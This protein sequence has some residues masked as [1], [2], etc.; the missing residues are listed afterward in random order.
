MGSLASALLPFPADLPPDGV[1][2][3]QPDQTVDAVTR[4]VRAFVTIIVPVYNDADRLQKCLQALT[5]QSYP[6]DCREIIVI[7]NGSDEDLSQMMANW[8]EI[9]LLH[10][11]R[12]GSYAARNCGIAVARGEILAFTD[13]DC[14]P[15]PEWLAAG[16][17]ALEANPDA[18]H[19]G[20]PVV[21]VPRNPEQRNLAELHQ[22]I[23]AFDQERYITVRQFSVTANLIARRW[24]FNKIGNFRDEL[25]SSGDCEWGQR[26]AAAGYS[27][28]YV[29]GMRIFHPARETI[30]ALRKKAVRISG[31]KVHLSRIQGKPDRAAVWQTVQGGR[32]SLKRIWNNPIER[33][34]TRRSQL[35]VAELSI[36]L[37]MVTEQLRVILGKEPRRQ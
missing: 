33:S 3:D 22:A 2:A 23:L 27:P 28:R 16:V 34:L 31:G 8:P 21:T 20:G 18:T 36:R 11:V 17:D 14:L 15:D 32:Y 6:E 26:A 37:A 9:R 10:Q 19:V 5:A 7:D 24:L 25:K 1:A 30:A 13:S 4:P 12:P 35:M 29:A